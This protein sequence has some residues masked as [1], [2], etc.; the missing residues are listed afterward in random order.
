MA[1]EEKLHPSAAEALIILAGLA[2]LVTKRISDWLPQ[3][4]MKSRLF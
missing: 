1:R 3:Q 4:D 2:C